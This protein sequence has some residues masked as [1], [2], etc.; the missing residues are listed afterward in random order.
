MINLDI[1]P[2][3]VESSQGE[4]HSFEPL[5][6]AESLVRETGIDMETA[7]E[8]TRRTL[9]IIANTGFK[10]IAAPHIREI[11]CGQLTVMGLHNARN[12]YTR[13]GI[14]LADVEDLLANG[15][16]ENSNQD[17]NPESSH[18][19][20][21][22]QVMEQYVH[23][24]ELS[25][26]EREMHLTGRIKIHGLNYWERPFCQEYDLRIILQYGIPPVNFNGVARSGPARNALVAVTHAAK[27]LAIVQ[28]EYSGGQGYDHF[29]TFLAPY[30]RGLP[31]RRSAPNE[32]DIL[33][34]AQ[35]FV[36]E[37]NQV[38]AARGGQAPFTSISCEP[39]IA[40]SLENVSAIGPGG[41]IVGVYGDYEHEARLFFRAL[42]DVY[43]AGDADGRMFAFPKHEV[44]ITR[45]GM[46]LREEDYRYCVEHETVKMGSTYFLNGCAPWMPDDIHSQCCRIIMTQEGLIQ[47][48]HDPEIFDW[49]THYN[50]MGSLQSVSI[51]LPRCAYLSQ[52]NNSSICDEIDVIWPV[53]EG[54]LLKKRQIVV[55]QLENPY[56]KIAFCRGV[57]PESHIR[58]QRVLDIRKSSLSV[59]F[60]GLNE[61]VLCVSGH[62]LHEPDG[63]EVGRG[64]L[65]HIQM[66]C[67][68]A[69]E[70]NH[71]KF[72]MWEQPAES[73]SNRFARLDM[74]YMPQY[75]SRFVLGGTGEEAYYTNSCHIRYD[76]DIGLGELIQLQ[77]DLHPIVQGGVISHIWLGEE[78]PDAEAL[79]DLTRNICMNTNTAYF[80]YTFDFSYC[81]ACHLFTRGRISD[82]CPRCGADEHNIEWYSKITGYYSRVKRWN[83]GKR[84][85]WEDRNRRNI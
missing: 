71:F 17:F 16:N 34:V 10:Q 53:V 18:T 57:I 24:H 67:L 80:S 25:E 3:Q 73:T 5:R 27:W 75:A 82:N 68:Q 2:K 45:K 58:S 54:I 62:E 74:E 12:R 42:V 6:I 56:G 84:A 35:C 15:S 8:V 21:A 39:C 65:E 40:E 69:T 1:F 32:L 66:R 30:L 33:Q 14:P 52:E 76:A 22:D 64:V 4:L 28:G 19:W 49:N 11:V 20:L 50:N 37:S 41:Q 43:A 23:L 7:S 46:T 63:Y 78:N 83:P 79:W 85:E 61:A 44:K 72:S 13:L 48:C 51:N 47:A 55:N 70:R 77:G 31:Y 81:T 38:F 60:V 26:I 29:T 36:F 9:R 59:G